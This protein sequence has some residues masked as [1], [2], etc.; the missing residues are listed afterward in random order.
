[1]GSLEMLELRT[2]LHE[3][4]HRQI[5]KAYEQL[6]RMADIVRRMAETTHR[7]TKGYVGQTRILDLTSAPSDQGR[8]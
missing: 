4:V 5:G 1:M 7:R 6:E 2:D 8:E 3:D